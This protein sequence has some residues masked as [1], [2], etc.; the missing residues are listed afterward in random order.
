MKKGNL[1]RRLPR[2]ATAA[3]AAVLAIVVSLFAAPTAA[4][5]DASG[6]TQ[7]GKICIPGVQQCIAGGMLRIDVTGRGDQIYLVK[8]SFAAG[9]GLQNW[10]FSYELRDTTGATVDRYKQFRGTYHE[11]TNVSGAEMWKPDGYPARTGEACVGVWSNAKHLATAC[12]SVYPAKVVLRNSGNTSKC[13]DVDIN[14]GGRD[15]S[16][17]QLWRCNGTAQQ[18]WRLAANGEVRSVRYPGMC[19]DA[20][21]NGNGADGSK[22]QIYGCNGQG[23]QKW[24][25]S[26]GGRI[27]NDRYNKC[28]DA[29]LNNIRNDGAKVQIWGCNSQP[30]QVWG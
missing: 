11:S 30:Q 4:Y 18:G 5:A 2:F 9:L 16:K 23:Q 20:D 27:M 3:L 6:Q 7:W 17:V 13:L 19:L 12:V 28:L 8:A 26:S 14:G 24:R 15:G 25:V 10:Q 1:L 22:V 21:T 29:D